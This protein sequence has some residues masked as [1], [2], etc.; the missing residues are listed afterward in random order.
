MQR[1]TAGG[2][3]WRGRRG[4]GRRPGCSGAGPSPSAAR[5]GSGGG[6]G[7]AGGGGGRRGPPPA[8]AA[9]QLRLDDDRVVDGPV[10]VLAGLLLAMDDQVGRAGVLGHVV[11]AGLSARRRRRA[12]CPS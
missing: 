4:R 10:Y 8:R 2:W 7:G 1:R 9:Q 5:G 12:P 11:D 3:G 6:G